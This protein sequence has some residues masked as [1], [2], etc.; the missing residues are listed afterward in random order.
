MKILKNSTT[1]EQRPLI[2]CGIALC[3]KVIHIGDD[4]GY[5]KNYDVFCKCCSNDMF[6]K[7]GTIDNDW[8]S[9]DGEWEE[10]E[11]DEGII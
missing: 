11:K 10:V 4:M 3:D 2:K 8:I 9:G 1:G 5:D 6:V 7:R